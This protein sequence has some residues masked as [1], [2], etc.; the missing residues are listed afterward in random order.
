MAVKLRLRRIGR[1]H[2]ALYQIVA[3]DER[4]P[5]DGKF[6]EK[7]GFYNPHKEFDKAQVDHRLA[8]KWLSYGAIPTDT[9]RSILSRE[10]VM[11]KLH[12]FRK[13]HT[14]DQVDAK[15][16][17]WRAQRDRE[18]DMLKLEAEKKAKE[19]IDKRA[20]HEREMRQQKAAKVAAKINEGLQAAK[21]ESE[22]DAGGGDDAPAEE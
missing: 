19:D 12:L 9:V 10:G 2:H 14:P 7:I 17:E 21:T 18:T 15:Y 1:R 4:A 8:L 13:K 5:R 22:S 6:L 16:R 3:A 11:L 20:A